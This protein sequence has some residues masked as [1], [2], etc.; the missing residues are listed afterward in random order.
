M[1]VENL[2]AQRATSAGPTPH[3]AL[4]L[5]QRFVMLCANVGSC[6]VA[7]SESGSFLKS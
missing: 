3:A 7:F 4:R 1:L 2:S 5:T 6:A